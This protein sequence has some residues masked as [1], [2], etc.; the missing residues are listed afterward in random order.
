[1][2]D[3]PNDIDLIV[4]KVIDKLSASR[5]GQKDIYPLAIKNRHIDTITWDKGFGGTLTLGGPLNADGFL[6]LLDGSS[7]ERVR[8]D[9][10]GI[11]VTD[12]KI[13]IKDSTNT[14]IL[15][16]TGLVST[17]NFN[18]GHVESVGG[19]SYTSL[20]FTDVA[21]ATLTF[22]LTRTANVFINFNVTMAASGMADTATVTGSIRLNVDG[23][24]EGFGA[25]ATFV[26]MYH[27]SGF[28]TSST[29]SSSSST[30]VQ[31]LTAGSHTIKLQASAST[32]GG[33]TL[34]L[35]SWDLTYI[36]L[37]S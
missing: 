21:T 6:S 12:G 7:V 24:L 23:T 2:P 37:G 30:T 33:D 8:L 11:T 18:N 15:D 20:T 34:D 16:A 32:S 19:S 10:S 22:S 9:N 26:P 17:A 4:Q 3:L 35:I 5:S 14:T 27:S 1:M 36:I 28:S 31:S 25:D 29:Q 13:I